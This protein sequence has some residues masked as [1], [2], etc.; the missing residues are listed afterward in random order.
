MSKLFL[1]K[2]DLAKLEELYR[3]GGTETMII[4]N[5]VANMREGINIIS[6][7]NINDGDFSI[8]DSRDNRHGFSTTDNIIFNEFNTDKVIVSRKFQCRECK[9]ITN[10]IPLG[11][12]VS[13]SV[14]EG[15][16]LYKMADVGFHSFECALKFI[17]DHHSRLEC[18]RQTIY[19]HSK[20]LL[21]SLFRE[22][23]GHDVQ[24]K[25]VIEFDMFEENGGCI[26]RDTYNS[27]LHQF[28]NTNCIIVPVKKVYMEK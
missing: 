17:N 21:F 5:E 1:P 10:G 8:R 12:P 14:I 19:S 25:E 13:H 6:S 3:N 27:S 7:G 18:R 15:K 16:N 26:H 20:Q 22:I 24:L 11:I 9:L 23:Y 4:P 28:V 2:I